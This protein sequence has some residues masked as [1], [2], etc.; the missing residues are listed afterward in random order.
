MLL[1]RVRR[2]VPSSSFLPLAAHPLPLSTGVSPLLSHSPCLS[3]ARFPTLRGRCD[4]RRPVAR[5]AARV[6]A[7][8]G[9]TD[10]Y[11]H[12]DDVPLRLCRFP[13]R[14]TIFLRRPHGARASPG[15]CCASDRETK[16]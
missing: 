10:A 13:L 16:C 12:A 14:I 7:G 6:R 5:R 9:T 15:S 3:T 2:V 1:R 4:T 11:I 8:H